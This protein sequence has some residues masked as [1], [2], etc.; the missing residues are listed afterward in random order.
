MF[1]EDVIRSLQRSIASG[2]VT[3]GPVSVQVLPTGICNAQ[4]LFCPIHSGLISRAVKERHAPRLLVKGGL[5][6]MGLYR[7][8]IDDLK[9]LG[10]TRRI[11]Y[12]GSGEPLIHPQFVEMVRYARKHLPD[13]S[14]VAVTNG[15]TLGGCCGDLIAAG[16]DEISVSLNAGTAK[17]WVV[18]N[19]KGDEGQFRAIV[20]ALEYMGRVKKRGR[21]K[22]TITSVLT[23]YN[24]HEAEQMLEIARKADSEALSF[25]RTMVFDLGD[26]E[27]NK[28]LLCTP[29]QFR[30]FLR[31]LEKLEKGNTGVHISLCG[32]GPDDGSLN[33][34]VSA[35]LSPCYAGLTFT[36]LFPDGTIYPCCQCEAMMGTVGKSR[37]KE[38][39]RAKR[40]SAFRNRALRI[41][42][43]G[44]I[45]GCVGDACGYFY[46]NQEYHRL[47]TL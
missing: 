47:L 46:E 41:P 40:Y 19:P 10:M 5:L 25:I 2:S 23:R 3:H 24:C 28:D 36:M 27:Y 30:E 31:T 16:I 7:D 4:C 21:T 12:T 8:F 14:L 42:Q 11:Q 33:T 37:F 35:H 45:P 1:S 20:E 15:V 17:T 6:D 13:C 22:L 9:D 34:E 18:L 43:L 39:W 26:V 32:S 44:R 38:V 29:D